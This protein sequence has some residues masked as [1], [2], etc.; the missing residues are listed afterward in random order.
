MRGWEA[1]SMPRRKCTIFIGVLFFLL[2][3]GPAHGGIPRETTP[4]SVLVQ[5]K[6]VITD[7]LAHNLMLASQGGQSTPVVTYDDLQRE[8]MPGRKS[9]GKA[10]LLS[11]LLPG[12]GQ[13]YTGAKTK[14]RIFFSAEATA[15]LAYGG[16]KIW[17]KQ[18]EDEFAGW[19][20]EHAG[21]DPGEKPEDFWQMITYYDSRQEYEIYGRA[22]EPDRPSYPSRV[23]WD[24]KWDSDASR[25][26][27]RQ[28]RNS[29][30]E[31]DRRASFSV[32]AMLLNRIIAAIDAYRSAKSYNRDLAAERAKTGFRL[33][34][35]PF[36]KNRKIMV[37]FEGVF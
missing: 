32:G 34:G 28:L 23:G 29:A 14:S 1:Y 3:Y 12:T 7:I 21:I 13:I 16:F 26:H 11:A 6:P 9:P 18:K 33:K 5:D 35:K 2:A 37:I 31:A 30:K 15:W 25:V 22:D 20:A 19:A 36:G 17:S 10:M 4:R 27:Y 24:W 8:S